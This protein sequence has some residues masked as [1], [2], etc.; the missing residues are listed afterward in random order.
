M[1]DLGKK[2]GLSVIAE[3]IEDADTAKWLCQ[4][5]CQEGQGYHYGRPMPGREFEERFLARAPGQTAT[6]AGPE[7]AEVA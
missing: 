5:G 6:A 4:M 2:L 1:I 7:L 3:G